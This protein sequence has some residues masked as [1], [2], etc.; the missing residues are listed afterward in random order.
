MAPVFYHH[1]GYNCYCCPT[2]TTLSSSIPTYGKWYYA[3]Y[4]HEESKKRVKKET[5]KEK[6]ARLAKEK[7]HSSW[8]TYNEKTFQIKTILQ[9]C[10]PRHKM[11][12][13]KH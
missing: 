1:S 9:V 10:K 5:K 8:K 7:M 3:N 12:F 4:T 11:F 2:P 6:V 13:Q